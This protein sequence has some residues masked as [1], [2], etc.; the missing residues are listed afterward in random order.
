MVKVT[1]IEERIVQMLYCDV[2]SS[3]FFN[4]PHTFF[5]R[6]GGGSVILT[7]SIALNATDVQ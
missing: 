5:K 3:T 2:L 1:D 4:P 6:G 7:Y